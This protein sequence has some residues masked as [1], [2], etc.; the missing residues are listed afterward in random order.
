ME[1]SNALHGWSGGSLYSVLRTQY[2]VLSTKLKGRSGSSSR[3]TPATP[4][5]TS[6]LVPSPADRQSFYTSLGCSFLGGILLWAA[7]PPLNLWP[8]A[9]LAP[10][11]W[12]YLVL[13]AQPMTRWAYFGIWLGG[14]AHWLAM[15]YGIALAHILLVVGWFL[16]A[17]YLGLYLPLFVGLCRLAVLRLRVSILLIA[18]VV[19]VGLE[20]ARGYVVT[21]FSAGLLGHSQTDWLTLLQIAD[22]FGAYGVS[23]LMMF[24]AAAITK[25]CLGEKRQA[26]P[27]LAAAAAMLLTLAYGWMRLTETPP[28]SSR[29]P[30]LVALIQGSR[31]VH[32]DMDFQQSMERMQHYSE[33]TQQAREN[34]RK[35]DIVIWPESMF[36][37]PLVVNSPGT[38][39]SKE[40]REAA[41]YFQREFPRG[42]RQAANMLNEP[43]SPEADTPTLFYFCTTTLDYGPD[44]RRVYNSALLA[45]ERGEIVSRYDKTHAVMFGE[46]VPFASWFPV[47]EDIFPIEGMTEGDQPV[48]ADVKGMSFCPSI[49]FESTIPH[50][51]RHQVLTLEKHGTPVDVLVNLTNDGWFYGSS[52][53]DLHLKCGIFRAIE[54]RRPMIIAANTGISANIEGS[55]RMLDRGPRRQPQVLVVSVQPDGR[56]PLY[57]RLGDWPAIACTAVCGLLAAW[58]LVLRRRDK[59]LGIVLPLAHETERNKPS[60]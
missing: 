13:R 51:I 5:T 39:S 12:L 4:S 53:L 44:R 41:L 18:P 59:K 45:N 47:I 56:H 52:I 23:F 60:D 29:A 30:Q 7:F 38:E 28:G 14:S 58:G 27:L 17:A 21:G 46:Y 40:E 48:A 1:P 35:L 33:L 22:V 37:L 20:L 24:V 25:V 6:R 55:G 43:G 54:N 8:I 3:E 10:L 49:C 19:W 42:V 16:L 57:H 32:I 15:L 26:W 11:P 34:Y 50:L 2:L 31:D 36:A 9:W